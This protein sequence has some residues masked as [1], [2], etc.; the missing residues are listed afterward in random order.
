MTDD[1][2]EYYAQPGPTTALGGHA[3]RVDALPSDPAALAAIVRG[4]I[5]HQGLVQAAGLELP[6]RRFEDRQRVGAA[7]I[8]E[9]VLALDAS[10]LDVARE[11]ADRMVGFCYHFAVLHCALL[12]AK[13]VPAR[14]RCGFAAYF[15]DGAWI[16]HWVTEYWDGDGWVVIDPDA[17]RDVVAPSDFHA[18]GL[19]WQR[20]RDGRDDPLAHGNWELWGWDELRGSLVSDV[21]ALNK[22][23]V[24]DWEPWCHWIAVADKDQ[25]N[26]ALDPEFDALAALVGDEKT[27][28]ALQRRF[29]ADARL[30]PPAADA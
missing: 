5:L 8:L 28:D 26:A 2:L 1:I 23:E 11:P 19:A 22:V 27:F 10:P 15:K 17:A 18:A 13:G 20:C 29:R 12:R 7:A 14:A 3:D 9:G 4:L 16:D 6:A 24:G 25:P 30:R 21:G